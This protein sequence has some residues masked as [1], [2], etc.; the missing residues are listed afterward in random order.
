MR[1][2]MQMGPSPNAVQI[3]NVSPGRVRCSRSIWDTSVAS[4]KAKMDKGEIA[5]ER[6]RE[7]LKKNYLRGSVLI[8]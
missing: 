6:K 2:F 3:F 4:L 1:L 7:A 5:A 8:I